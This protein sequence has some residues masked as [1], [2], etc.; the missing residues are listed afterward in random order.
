MKPIYAHCR[1]CTKRYDMV[2]WGVK[3]PSCNKDKGKRKK[4]ILL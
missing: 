2:Q 3:C 4:F 1:I